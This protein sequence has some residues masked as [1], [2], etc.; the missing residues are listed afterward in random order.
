MIDGQFIDA[1][2]VFYGFLRSKQGITTTY[3]VPGA[4][5]S[6]GQGTMVGISTP[7]GVTTGTYLDANNVVHGYLLIP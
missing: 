2:G 6:A 5:T 4:G 1:S 7:S 3:D